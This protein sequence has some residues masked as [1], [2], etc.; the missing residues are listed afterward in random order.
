MSSKFKSTPRKFE[1]K[2]ILEREVNEDL[3]RI[4]EKIKCTE[5]IVGVNDE[6]IAKTNN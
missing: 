6:N 2:E 4:E 1:I 3:V 5:V